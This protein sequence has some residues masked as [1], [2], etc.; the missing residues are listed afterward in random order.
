[1]P[2]AGEG[3]PGPV[4]E[5]AHIPIRVSQHLRNDSSRTQIVEPD[6]G[7]RAA[8]VPD[9]EQVAAR[10]FKTLEGQQQ[11]SNIISG[12]LGLGHRVFMTDQE[13]L[14]FIMNSSRFLKDD[15]AAQS[16]PGVPAASSQLP[17]TGNFGGVPSPEVSFGEDAGSQVFFG[18][19]ASPRPLSVSEQSRLLKQVA[20]FV[21]D[22]VCQLGMGDALTRVHRMTQSKVS[23]TTELE[24]LDFQVQLL[25]QWCCAQ[26]D[27]TYDRFLAADIYQREHVFP[28]TPMPVT[29]RRLDSWMRPKV[30]AAIPQHIQD[31][32][33]ERTRMYNVRDPTHVVCSLCVRSLL[34]VVR[35]RRPVWIL[36]SGTSLLALL[37]GL[38]SK[39]SAAGKRK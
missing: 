33:A 3:T 31:I 6:G 4:G 25:W 36:L 35:R 20:T 34:R 13:L 21:K 18:E 38:L 10:Q 12:R 11:F 37:L 9:A 24:Q 30:M 27:R 39:S 8:L 1:M 14:E 15:A 29:W 28:T 22:S 7:R 16:S 23:V 2:N 17:G 32:A 19:E 26:A 5:T